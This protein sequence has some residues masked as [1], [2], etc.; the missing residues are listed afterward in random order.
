MVFRTDQKGA[1]SVY[2][3]VAIVESINPDGSVTTSEC[4]ASLQGRTVS[5]TFTNVSDFQYIHY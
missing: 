2:G 4:G 5:R 1:G 3:H